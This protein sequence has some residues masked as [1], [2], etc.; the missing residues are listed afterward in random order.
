ML[1]VGAGGGLCNVGVGLTALRNS[2]LAIISFLTLYTIDLLTCLRTASSNENPL[3]T[4]VFNLGPIGLAGS[5]APFVSIYLL[6]SLLGWRRFR[7]SNTPL[8]VCL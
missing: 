5:P 2:P 7:I 4:D 6:L 3:Y 1:G 8:V